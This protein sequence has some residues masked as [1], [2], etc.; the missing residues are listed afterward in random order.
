MELER[1]SKTWEAMYRV[2]ATAITL[3]LI[4]GYVSL[5]IGVVLGRGV[6]DVIRV[7]LTRRR[8]SAVAGGGAT[9]VHAA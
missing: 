8:S 2:V 1:A 4:V 9:M 5:G 3:P 6:V 7:G